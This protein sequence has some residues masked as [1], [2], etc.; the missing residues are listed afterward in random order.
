MKRINEIF[1]K[2]N[3]LTTMQPS[4]VEEDRLQELQQLP[5]Q[6]EASLKE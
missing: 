6:T 2:P 1:T 5:E 3:V 4:S